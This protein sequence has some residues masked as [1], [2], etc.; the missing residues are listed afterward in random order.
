MCN[1]QFWCVYWLGNCLIFRPFTSWSEAGHQRSS[2]LD[3]RDMFLAYFN[4]G[5]SSLSKCLYCF[6]L[7]H[8][9]CQYILTCIYSPCSVILLPMAITFYVTWWF[10]HFV[11]G[12]FSP[13]YTHLGID[14]FGKLLLVLIYLWLVT[15]FV[16][17]HE[18]TL[19][20]SRR[21]SLREYILISKTM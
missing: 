15:L 21:T 1:F 4:G 16:G 11:D 8:K 2:W 14:I 18:V 19:M 12:F 3:G 7:V 5:F 9:F 17:D 13:I 10:I 6:V 20:L